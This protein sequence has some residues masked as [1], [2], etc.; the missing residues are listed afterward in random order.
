MKK[1]V[2]TAKG[3]KISSTLWLQRQLND[4]YVKLAK[5]KGYRSRA[6]FKLIELDEK[7]DLFKNVNSVLDLGAAPG[8][9]SQYCASK[10]QNKQG[11]KIIAVDLKEIDNISDVEFI[12]GDFTDLEIQQQISERSAKFD[13]IISDMAPSTTGH[14]KTDHLRITG[15]VEE[16]IAFAEEF[17]NK[18]GRF[19]AKLFQ[20]GGEKELE[21]QLKQNFTKVKFI[22]PK[23][24]R[25]DSTEFFIYAEGF[26]TS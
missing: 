15:L 20:G 8:G 21:K 10:M 2:H 26:I 18:D 22:K 25:S 19:L 11:S 7:L 14:Q 17:L 24:S 16:A 1:R 23:C 9:W 3:R 12:A 13:L 4:P 5:Q 6:V